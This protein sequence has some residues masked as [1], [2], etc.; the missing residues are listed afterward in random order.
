RNRRPAQGR[1]RGRLRRGA[2]QGDEPP[3]PAR[4]HRQPHP[5]GACRMA[6]IRVELAGRSYEVRVGG[7]LL[8]DLA[9]QC[10]PLL[11]KSRVPVV[12]DANVAQHWRATVDASLTA[13][14]LEP[15]WL[16]L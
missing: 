8:A 16:V 10:G 1:A 3:R 9:G 4:R 15:R 7:G 5:A 14:G 13:M 2:D 6:V 12:T 11:R